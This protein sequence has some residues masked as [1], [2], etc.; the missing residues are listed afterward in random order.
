MSVYNIRYKF[1]IFS[2]FANI[3]IDLFL[4]RLIGIIWKFSSCT[5]SLSVFLI[6][7]NSLWTRKWTW[8]A[9]GPEF[10]WAFWRHSTSGMTTHAYFD[11][12]NKAYPAGSKVIPKCRIIIN[13]QNMCIG[14]KRRIPRSRLHI[15]LARQPFV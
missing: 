9:L 13:Y 4:L 6:T 10:I 2:I 7:S 14:L 8:W 11:H 3:N 15:A 12:L 5:A 1:D